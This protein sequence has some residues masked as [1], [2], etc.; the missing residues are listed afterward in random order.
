MPVTTKTPVII[1]TYN[2]SQ[3]AGFYNIS[4]DVLNAW[5][6]DIS[7]LGEYTGRRYT[8]R[9]VKMIFEHCGHPEK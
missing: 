8:L 1:D 4:T 2:K 9:Q 5:T 3:V 7:G 6:A